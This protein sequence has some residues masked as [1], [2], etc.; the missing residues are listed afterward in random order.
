MSQELPYTGLH[1]VVAEDSPHMR[2]L[3]RSMLRALG[4]SQI[5]AESNG[6][7]AFRLIESSWPDVVLL[8]WNMPGPSGLDILRAIRNLEEPLRRTPVIMITAHASERRLAEAERYGVNA[9]LCKPLSVVALDN[10]LRK[11]IHTAYVV[12]EAPTAVK[13]RARTAVRKSPETT[14]EQKDAPREGRETAYL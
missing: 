3:L 13:T 10:H 14:P 4:F 12:E 5:S 2:A 11:V 6:P 8:D 7:D 9:F 1:A